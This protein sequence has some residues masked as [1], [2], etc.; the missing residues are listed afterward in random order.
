MACHHVL[1]TWKLAISRNIYLSTAQI[2][3]TLTVTERESLSTLVDAERILQSTLLNM[4][5]KKLHYKPGIDL[6]VTNIN[7]QFGK[8][9]AF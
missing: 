3:G 2:L 8:Y 7:K 1:K 5:L 4:A 9:A 6:F